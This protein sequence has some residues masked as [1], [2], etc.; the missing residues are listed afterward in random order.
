MIDN[1]TYLVGKGA[2]SGQNIIGVM[3]P[4]T[5]ETGDADPQGKYE[6]RIY[7]GLPS[8]GMV[9]YMQTDSYFVNDNHQMVDRFAQ[10]LKTK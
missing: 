6:L 5:P 1:R 10:V 3:E 4:V 7:T 2:L 9:A 8:F